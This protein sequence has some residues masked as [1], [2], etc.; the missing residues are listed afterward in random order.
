MMF[1]SIE[2]AVKSAQD[3]SLT[4]VDREK[5]L[6][7]LE[8]SD[9]PAAIQTLIMALEDD[10]HGVRWAAAEVL[11]A[12]GETSFKY[13]LEALSK[14]NSK[15]LRDGAI[16]VIH[17]NSSEKLKSKSKELVNSLSS[18]AADIRSMEEATMLLIELR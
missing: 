18:T 8:A 6:R 14:P 5:A 3:D 11:A 7:Y 12:Q 2:D 16:V 10:D 4:E 1:N 17:Q 9:D 13:L 15:M